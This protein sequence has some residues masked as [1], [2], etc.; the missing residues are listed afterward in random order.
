M[1]WVC[2]RAPIRCNSGMFSPFPVAIPA[3]CGWLA[4]STAGGGA[5]A[6]GEL[7]LT[8]ASV[9]IALAVSA[10]SFPSMASGSCVAALPTGGRVAAGLAGL[11]VVWLA[12]WLCQINCRVARLSCSRLAIRRL[13]V[14]PDGGAI[15][16]WI[17]AIRRFRLS[18]SAGIRSASDWISHCCKARPEALLS[19]RLAGSCCIKVVTSAG[20]ATS[21]RKGMDSLSRDMIG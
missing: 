4:E 1:S 19:C 2:S 17:N 15:C 6:A 5:A 3:V 9:G 11:A 8:V 20:V 13:S 18:C 16:C 10:G 7:G 14:V 12:D 21:W